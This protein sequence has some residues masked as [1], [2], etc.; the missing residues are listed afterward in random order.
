MSYD[1][2]YINSLLRKCQAKIRR[3]DNLIR[4]YQNR[5]K[6]LCRKMKIKNQVVC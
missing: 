3:N 2:N 4:E 6:L 1:T 5:L